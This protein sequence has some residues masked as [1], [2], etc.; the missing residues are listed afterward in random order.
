MTAAAVTLGPTAY[1][2]LTRGSGIVALLLLTAI[3]LLGVLGPMRIA[4][5]ERWPRFALD[6]LHRDLSLLAVVVIALHV[7]VSVL[8]GF[9][10]IG[11]IDGV[12]PFV[13]AYRPL[14]LGLGALAFD[15]MLALVIT[16]LLRRRLGLRWWRAVHWLA[17]ASW[18]LAVL[19]GLGTGSDSS[20]VWALSL[21]L[22]C[23][24]IV[25]AAVLARIMRS[26][27]L[28]GSGRSAA[29]AATLLTPAGL[30][31]FTAV[32]PLAPDWARRAGTPARLLASLA[33][34]AARDTRLKLPFA[35][36]L[37]GTIEQTAG[38]SGTILDI[39][40]RLSGADSGSLR[41]RMAGAPS[42]S[43]VAL[44]GSQVDLLLNA[45]PSALQGEVT[46]L[47][48]DTVTARVSGAQTTLELT[49]DL[50][51]DPQAG[52]VTGSL[53]GKAG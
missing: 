27:A 52:T 50:Q 33:P 37:A 17:Y 25:A 40:L 12:V 8:D 43:T 9:A 29:L 34:A 1:W 35:D 16:S 48:G 30:A 15:L 20:Q 19:H 36:Q 2:Y 28:R 6:T 31:V 38:A 18:P 51:I 24:V 23:V 22:G 46:G 41:I 13:S 32:G 7:V 53:L 14:W 11:L 39:E 47:K 45:V 21:T 42:G 26:P 10:P 5:G 3:I 44:T 49:A 4:G